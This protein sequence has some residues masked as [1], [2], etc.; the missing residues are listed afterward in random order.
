MDTP[1]FPDEPPAWAA[2]SLPTQCKQLEQHAPSTT[3]RTYLTFRPQYSFGLLLVRSLVAF[4]REQWLST[5]FTPPPSTPTS[6][7]Q[8]SC[9]SPGQQAPSPR[10]IG[11]AIDAVDAA[12]H[13]VLIRV[14]HPDD[15]PLLSRLVHQVSLCVESMPSPATLFITGAAF[16]AP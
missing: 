3:T 12:L 8:D 4:V 5:S 9:G 14:A 2:P 11:N 10:D 15:A 16:G 1:A 6:L 13:A 7:S